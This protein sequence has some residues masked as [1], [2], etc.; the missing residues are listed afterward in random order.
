MGYVFK[1]TITEKS[2]GRTKRRKGRFYWY[3]VI[4][5][6]GRRARNAL[7][8]PNGAKVTDKSVAM[9][10]LRKLERSIERKAAGLQNKPMESAKLPVRIL[11]A[12]YAKFLRG[13]RRT[14]KHVRLSIVRILELCRR[15]GIDRLSELHEGAITRAIAS[16]A[17][18]GRSTKTLNEYRSAL[19]SLCKWAHGLEGMIDRNPVE[20]IAKQESTGDEKLTRALTPAEAERL[21]EVAG[22][23]RLHYAM[24]LY[25]GL[26]WDELRKLQWGDLDLDPVA[27]SIALRAR[28]TKA[29]RGDAVLI[30]SDL[31]KMLAAAKPAMVDPRAR[32]F[33]AMPKYETFIRDCAFA[34]IIQWFKKGRRWR[35]IPD[36]RSTVINPHALR[37][38]F[39]SWLS[40]SQV[41]PRT[42]QM[43]ARHTDIRLTMKTYT[44]PRLLDGRSAVESLPAL[45]M[46]SVVAPV[47]HRHGPPWP[48]VAQNRQPRGTSTMDKTLENRGFGGENDDRENWRRRESNPRLYERNPL[49]DNGSREEVGGR[50]STGCTPIGDP[51]AF[52]AQ[53]L[54][55]L[56][57]F[58]DTLAPR[59]LLDI[60][61]HII[62]PLSRQ[63]RPASAWAGRGSA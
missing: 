10:E 22:P 59:D 27:P 8:L 49:S 47:V 42:A 48:V 28:A 53:L 18:A 57:A 2:G 41:A 56:S 45:S 30:R 44:D 13:R 39:V 24:A 4:D 9:E 11:V 50:C 34:G 46:E 35:Q 3:S 32:V 63:A 19:N 1:P 17:G 51:A 25:T 31:G 38:T 40:M 62:E 21:L 52:K 23:R 60:R 58:L 20:S 14:P 37:K 12:R 26:R 36:A 5:E 7:K 29:R 54:A 55:D 43:L 6:T 15:G 33:G 61:K 16:L